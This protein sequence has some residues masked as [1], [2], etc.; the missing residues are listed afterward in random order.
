MEE[1]VEE[2]VMA[3]VGGTTEDTKRKIK[4]FAINLLMGGGFKSDTLAFPSSS[5]ATAAAPRPT[6]PPPSP[7]GLFM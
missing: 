4:Q 3:M 6:L 5:S 1:E 7:R 2:E